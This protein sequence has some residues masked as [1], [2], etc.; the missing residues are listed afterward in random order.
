[1]KLHP[2]LIA[3]LLAFASSLAFAGTPQAAPATT[4]AAKTVPAAPAKVHVRHAVKKR[5]V[6]K[7]CHKNKAG[8]VHCSK[9]A[10][11][12]TARRAAAPKK[13]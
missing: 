1:M 8:K 11:Q 3:P 6:A 4:P 12:R 10:V 5:V 7:R 2:L 13:A 9:R